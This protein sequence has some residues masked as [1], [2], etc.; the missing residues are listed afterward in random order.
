MK[1]NACLNEG[2]EKL[3]MVEVFDH[4]E[5]FCKDCYVYEIG[6]DPELIGKANK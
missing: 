5:L 6:S 4:I 1:C 2:Y 3:Y